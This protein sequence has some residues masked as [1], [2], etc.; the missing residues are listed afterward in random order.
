[1]VVEKRKLAKSMLIVKTSAGAMKGV[2]QFLRNRDWTLTTTHEIKDAIIFLTQ[3]KPSFVLI[4]VDHAN[5]NVRKLPKI[6]MAAFPCCV[7]VYAEKASPSNF[8]VLMDSGV[9]YKINPPIT[10]PAIERAVN[11]YIRDLEQASK[12]HNQDAQNAANADK[13]QSAHNQT[14]SS[15][16]AKGNFEFNVE[17]KGSGQK[18]VSY[19]SHDD[20]PQEPTAGNSLAQSL[21]LKLNNDDLELPKIKSASSTAAYSPS[22]YGKD[23][24][25]E[26]LIVQKSAK[27][28]KN[29]PSE[30]DLALEINAKVHSAKGGSSEGQD[31]EA[32]QSGIPIGENH[33][34]IQSGQGSDLLIGKAG[35]GS[36]KSGSFDSGASQNANGADISIEKAKNNYGGPQ[37]PGVDPDG[38]KDLVI[39]E[40]QNKAASD[41]PWQPA[42]KVKKTEAIVGQE[43]DDLETAKEKN[44]ADA[45]HVRKDG[46]FDKSSIFVKG[47][48]QSLD[49]TVVKGDGKIENR[50]EQNSH[51]ACIIVES[52]R[53]SGY[54]VAA[55][56]KD[57]KIDNHFVEL[58]RIKLM[59]FLKDNGETIEN[60]S[61]LQLK[62]RQVDFEG[63]AI[64]YAQFLKKSVH[65]GNEVAMAFFP[66]ASAQT[67]V[68]ELASA[69]MVSVKT[70][71]IQAD[72]PLEFNMYIH[73]PSNKKYI[74]Y[75][76]QGGMFLSEQ[77]KRLSKQG[78]L[79]M[80]IQKED[81]QNLSKF[82]AQ[83]HL[84]SLIKDYESKS[85][86]SASTTKKKKAA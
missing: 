75:T 82:K 48:N 6:V 37:H 11:K 52:P 36:D 21:L 1:M 57:K 38:L 39:P 53:F 63:W 41:F 50:L 43:I 55:M 7:M 46:F 76:P 74:L 66:F 64:E 85:G 27:S 58:I 79:N 62:V 51:F 60:E 15:S 40:S 35:K 65:K 5:S 56:G 54:L 8:K 69:K 2:E 13:N 16:S 81:V 77:K 25:G 33:N 80:H 70:E 86:K 28:G 45:L 3:H 32:N 44:Q 24:N 30:S 71:D 59:K 19:L 10:G 26:S 9:E 72:I 4:C 83:N 23:K 78:V 18:P 84:N 67:P 14:I 29:S 61:N 12:Q 22:H 31:H 20:K 42:G 49:D 68:S 73:L 17:I 47:V 34:A